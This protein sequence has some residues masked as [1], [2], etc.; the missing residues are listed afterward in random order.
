MGTSITKQN[1]SLNTNDLSSLRLVGKQ[2]GR[3]PVGAR[4]P[5]DDIIKMNL[6]EIIWGGMDRI[7]L[8]QDR[9][10]W[11]VLLITI[12]NFRVPKYVDKF[13]SSPETGDF[14]RKAQLCGVSKG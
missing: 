12:M 7:Y 10:H 13:W 8:V 1:M 9:D 2:E 4:R 6:R 11:S 5:R 14:S 3:R